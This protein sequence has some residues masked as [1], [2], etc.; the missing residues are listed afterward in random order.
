MLKRMSENEIRQA[1]RVVL[2]KI[3]QACQR[4]NP[5]SNQNILPATY[6]LS[7][8]VGIARCDPSTGGC[9]QTQAC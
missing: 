9:K 3:E 8:F 1:L 4:R 5:V 7:I 6:L 2:N